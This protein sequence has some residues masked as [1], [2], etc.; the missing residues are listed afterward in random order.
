MLNMK[1]HVIAA[2]VLCSLTTLSAVAQQSK[3][4]PWMVRAR[5]VQLDSAN[6]DNT[7]LGLTVNNKLIAD[8]DITYF[9]NRNIAVELLL[10]VAQKHNVYSNGTTI[11]SLKQLPPT[12]TVQYHFDGYAVKPYVGAGINYTQFSSVNILGGNATLDSNSWGGALQAGVDIPLSGNMYLNVDLKK[13]QIGTDVFAG[14]VKAGTFKV[15]PLLLG[16]GVGWRF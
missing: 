4:G 11:G 14:G 2:A 7:G 5:L 12:V 9:L 3:E 10:T 6:S 16:V 8:L 1:K 15:D 13:I